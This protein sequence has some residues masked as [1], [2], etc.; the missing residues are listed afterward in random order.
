M[1]PAPR[2][3]ER[4]HRLWQDDGRR[5]ITCRWI[6]VKPFR[7]DG[8]LALGCTH[9]GACYGQAK[10]DGA[11]CSGEREPGADDE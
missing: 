2:T 10:R 3:I 7:P 1:N 4:M 8:T 6:E 5:C 9:P 11:C